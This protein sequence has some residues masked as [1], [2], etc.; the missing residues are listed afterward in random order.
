MVQSIASAEMTEMFKL[1][2]RY[3][4][5]TEDIMG[6][7]SIP[8]AQ[9]RGVMLYLGYSIEDEFEKVYA[10][11]LFFIS[12]ENMQTFPRRNLME[13]NHVSL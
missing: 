8:Q 13:K 10:Q 3:P 4:T 1:A 9:L 5:G 2:S 7:I 11:K 6:F 12:R